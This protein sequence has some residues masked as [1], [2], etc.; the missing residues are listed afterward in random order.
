MAL[1]VTPML[2]KTSQALPDGGDW[3]FEPK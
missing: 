2:A 1:P 3:I